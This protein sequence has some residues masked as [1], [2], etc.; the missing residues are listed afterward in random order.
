MKLRDHSE[1]VYADIGCLRPLPRI[2]YAM[3]QSIHEDDYSMDGLLQLLDGEPRFAAQ[4]LDGVNAQPNR[5]PTPAR[6]LSGAVAFLGGAQLVRWV[7]AS[8]FASYY[9]GVDQGYLL[10]E[11]AT[12][13]HGL[14]CGIV[15]EFL[16]E[17]SGAVLPAAAFTAGL[18]HD[19]GKI[20][21]ARHLEPLQGAFRQ[22][23]Q[24]SGGDLHATERSI[25][26][27]DHATTGGI[28]ADRWLLPAALRR[29]I[30]DH[31]DP[32]RVA[33]DEV[34][35]PLVHA[36]DA[37]CVEIGLGRGSDSRKPGAADPLDRFGLG[38]TLLRDAR[39]ML[40]DELH[41]LGAMLAT[42]AEVPV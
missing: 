19:L 15:A 9:A 36:A 38:W 39:A 13:E 28:I 8:C 24:A 20:V 35:T 10:P 12:F 6:S 31:H 33:A 34:L 7:S 17:R 18:L 22:A 32:R 29:C 26:G 42:R 1:A 5:M 30:R 16:A 21:L 23:L 2:A 41:R 3:L 11:G 40:I 27:L 25:V 37:A 4:L 14:A